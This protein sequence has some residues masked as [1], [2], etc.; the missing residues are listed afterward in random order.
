MEEAY[1]VARFTATGPAA[2]SSGSGRDDGRRARVTDDL[3]VTGVHRYI[4]CNH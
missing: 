4:D 1:S 3:N 2:L